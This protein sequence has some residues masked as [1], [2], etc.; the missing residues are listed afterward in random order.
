MLNNALLNSARQENSER[1]FFSMNLAI[2]TWNV[3]GD[4]EVT[5]P[6][7]LVVIRMQSPPCLSLP[8]RPLYAAWNLRGEPDLFQFP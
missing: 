5:H 3:P 7:S 1:F 6:N 2:V 8:G 4:L